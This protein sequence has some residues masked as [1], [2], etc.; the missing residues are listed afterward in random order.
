MEDLSGRPPVP[1]KPD[2]LVRA[3]RRL[4][5]A[6]WVVAIAT[7]LQLAF[8]VF[9]NTVAARRMM[10]AISADMSKRAAQEEPTHASTSSIS[11]PESFEGKQFNELTTEKKIHYASV[12]LLTK[13]EKTPKRWREIITEIVKVKPGTEFHFKVGEEYPELS[14][15]ADYACSGDGNIVFLIGSPAMMSESSSYTGD[16]LDSFGGL[17]I[18]DLREQVKREGQ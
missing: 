2:P 6:V 15:P 10:R 13:H 7:L 9:A 11:W 8:S 14:T 5:V 4:T 3:V 18:A 17:R 1:E 12:I 16:R